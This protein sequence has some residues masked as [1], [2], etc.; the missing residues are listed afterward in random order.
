[1]TTHT[2][3]DALQTHHFPLA[4]PAASRKEPTAKPLAIAGPTADRAAHPDPSGVDLT[5][6]AEVDAHLS[7][8]EAL[9]QAQLDALP[10][11]DLDPVAA[12][13]RE[14]LT[15]ILDEVRVARAR[16]AAGL[17]GVCARCDSAIPE[18]RLQLRPWAT[19]CAACAS[20]ARR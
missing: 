7:R 6:P 11:V 8:V 20:G 16:L 1:M 2:Y 12:A 4:G 9:R 3:P 17:Y 13:H 15:R 14:S 10:H 5:V 19:T 18:A